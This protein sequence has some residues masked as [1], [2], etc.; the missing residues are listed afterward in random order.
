MTKS[1]WTIGA[2]AVV[3][4][5][6]VV[7]SPLLYAEDSKVISAQKDYY[8][9]LMKNPDS[10]PLDRKNRYQATVQK[11]R[12]EQ[13]RIDSS[14]RVARINAAL[15]KMNEDAKKRRLADA[16][17]KGKPRASPSAS[18]SPESL[19][20]LPEAKKAKPPVHTERAS[21]PGNSNTSVDPSQF[22]TILDFTKPPAPVVS[23]S[24]ASD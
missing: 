4:F 2:V 21:Y 10:T 17:S 8:Q 7:N 3:I 9:Y 12:S 23:P 14:E 18:A 6:R 1:N 5:V 16:S 15:K 19:Y 22:P 20:T 13:N 11:A 24:P